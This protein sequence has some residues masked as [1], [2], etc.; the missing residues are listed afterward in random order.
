MSLASIE[1]VELQEVGR[2]TPIDKSPVA[3]LR[4]NRSDDQMLTNSNEDGTQYPKLSPLRTAVVCITVSG[5]TFVTSMS[6]GC[7]TTAIPSMADELDMA[8]GLILWPA[9]IYSL[10][11]GCTFILVG[12][13]ADVL[14]SR[15]VYLVGCVFLT[16][17]V[18]ACGLART[19]LELIA[20]RGL[21][22]VA[23]SLCLPTAIS[24]LTQT[25][26]PGRAR[27]RGLA[28]QGASMPIGYSAGLFIGG[29]FV[30]NIGWR[31]GWYMTA[32]MGCLVFGSGL[33]SIPPDKNAGQREWSRLLTGVDWVGALTL[34]ACLGL[35]SYV[36]A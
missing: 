2:S 34:S 9:A 7:L 32:I 10:T 8:K 13:I 6:T 33:W 21:M 16:G 20:F 27:T 23:S 11:S 31:W 15:L 19:G 25:F 26:A 4:A 29:A 3:S 28:V 24:I 35:V 12:S 1:N 17:C 22:G 18:L 36:L 5:I 14:G 30:A